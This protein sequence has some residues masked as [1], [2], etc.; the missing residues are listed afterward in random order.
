MH[1]IYYLVDPKE[2]F[3]GEGLGVWGIVS[4]GRS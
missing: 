4:I 3:S 2:N 1:V